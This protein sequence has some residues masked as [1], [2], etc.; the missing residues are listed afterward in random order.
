MTD[1]ATALPARPADGPFD[2][3]PSLPPGRLLLTAA[4]T[5]AVVLG[6]YEAALRAR[7]CFASVANTDALWAAHYN[8]LPSGAASREAVAIIGASR[9]Q[10]GIDLPSM[11]AAWPDRSLHQLAMTSRRSP[12]RVLQ[13]LAEETDFAGSVIASTVLRFQRGAGFDAQTDLLATATES[14]SWTAGP[15]ARMAAWCQSRAA[16]LQSRYGW[17]P[18][19]AELAR[20][21]FIAGP[22]PPWR[23]MDL[24]RQI[25]LDASAA[26]E[27][28]LAKL[29]DA[30]KPTAYETPAD[31]ASLA[32]QF[33]QMAAWAAA[34]EARG[35]RVWFVRLPIQPERIAIELEL[36]PTVED[37]SRLEAALAAGGVDPSRAIDCWSVAPL[38]DFAPP[39]GS[40]L[41]IAESPTFTRLLVEEMNRRAGRE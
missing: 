35:G 14:T 25:R 4:I 7:G 37:W 27:Q 23:A 10:I 21:R 32:D 33:P 39:D 2:R 15:D 13:H 22:Q 18:L 8:A 9:M 40:H 19:L 31:I 20:G 26:S 38:A 28:R 36:F 11:Q 24:Q 12:A 1:A 3:T 17:R 30:L 41:D 29:T 6:G 16:C 5:L 34:I